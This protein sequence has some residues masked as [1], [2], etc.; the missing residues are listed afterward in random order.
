METHSAELHMWRSVVVQAFNDATSSSNGKEERRERASARLW[1]LS[2]SRDFRF[3]CSMALL[4][5]DAVK[6][7]ASRLQDRDWVVRFQRQ[8]KMVPVL[9]DNEEA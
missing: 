4:D 7:S 8:K 5:S 9:D 3:V 6:E 1:L 2:D